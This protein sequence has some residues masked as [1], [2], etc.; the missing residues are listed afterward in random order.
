MTN[1][2][3]QATEDLMK[4][5]I[6]AFVSMTVRAERVLREVYKIPEYAA[7][8]FNEKEDKLGKQYAWGWGSGY[9]DPRSDNPN[10]PTDGFLD[11]SADFRV[12]SSPVSRGINSELELLADAIKSCEGT[13]IVAFNEYVAYARKVQELGQGVFSKQNTATPTSN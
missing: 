2:P 13:G 3:T 6:E 9:Y 5:G 8:R 10:L 11:P 7:I 4:K 1:I 12:I